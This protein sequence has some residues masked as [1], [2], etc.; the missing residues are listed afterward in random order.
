MKMFLYTSLTA[1]L[2]LSFMPSTA[3]KDKAEQNWL[4]GTWKGEGLQ[5]D[6]AKWDIVLTY[7]SSKKVE[8]DYP[9]LGCSGKWKSV[10]TEGA[11]TIFKEKLSTGKDK[12]DKGV[13]IK[14]Y[15]VTNSEVRVDFYVPKIT[16][17]IASGTLKKQ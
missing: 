10:S 16:A 11:L 17:S 1:F 12:C 4:I 8:I 2:F 15:K 14:L 9:T 7:N 5:I 3:S 13:T 6:G